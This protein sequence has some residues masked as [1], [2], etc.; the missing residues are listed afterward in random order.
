[1]QERIGEI[2]E[3]WVQ[4][5]KRHDH[6]H[7]LSKPRDQIRIPEQLRLKRA[8]L[9]QGRAKH[10]TEKADLSQLSARISALES[11]LRRVR[12]EDNTQ[13]LLEQV[14]ERLEE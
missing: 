12:Q 11:R 7:P 8:S 5:L 10:N 4:I 1:M 14:L 6:L 2:T 9:L 3:K 13:A